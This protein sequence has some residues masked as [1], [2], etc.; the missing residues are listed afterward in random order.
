MVGSPEIVLLGNTSL[1]YIR[2]SYYGLQTIVF[3][4]YCPWN[5]I[6]K[7]ETMDLSKN[8]L[9]CIN[10]SVLIKK[11]AV[12]DWSS[13]K[14]LYLGNNK[15]GDIHGNFCNKDKN[16]VLGFLEPLTNLRV[17]DISNNKVASSHSLASL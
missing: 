16:N 5:I 6:F 7:L 14:Y 10:T 17:L 1:K 11:G 9:R 2:A 3:S 8:N 4:V 12:C 13:L 15:L